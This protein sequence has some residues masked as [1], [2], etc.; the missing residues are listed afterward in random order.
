MT[1]GKTDVV[2]LLVVW[3]MYAFSILL[4]KVISRAY[5]L[6]NDGMGSVSIPT[7]QGDP[8]IFNRNEKNRY[9]RSMCVCVCNYS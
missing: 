4:D 5:I 9:W 8:F 6:R 3:F 7:H 1:D 2:L